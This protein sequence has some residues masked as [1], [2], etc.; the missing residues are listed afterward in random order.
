MKDLFKHGFIKIQFVNEKILFLQKNAKRKYLIKYYKY[1]IYRIME[2][3]SVSF[4]IKRIVI[5]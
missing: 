2:R 5:F 4:F 3:D 1:L